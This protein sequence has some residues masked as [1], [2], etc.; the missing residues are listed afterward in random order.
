MDGH[1]NYETHIKE[2]CTL[3]S[4]RV[5][6]LSSNKLLDQTTCKEHLEALQLVHVKSLRCA[7][8]HV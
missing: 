3:V 8:M 7:P 5:S 2:Y 4:T 6:R 1:V